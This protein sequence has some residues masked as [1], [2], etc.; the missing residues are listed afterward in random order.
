M[1]LLTFYNVRSEREL[2][3]TVPERIDW[4][5]FLGY[6]L[7]S[8]IPDHSV[9]SKARKRWGVEAFRQF[10]ERIVWQCVEAGQVDGEKIF[11]DSSLI[12]A[13]ASNSSV[14]DRQSLRYQVGRHYKTLEARLTEHDDN[15]G[16]HNE[17][18]RRFVSPTDPDAAI[19]RRGTAKLTYQTHRAVD[20]EAEVITAVTVTPGDV[21]EAHVMT[22]LMDTHAD[23]TG[24]TAK[25]I[26]ADSKYGTIE[27]FLACY[28]RGVAAHIPDLHDKMTRRSLKEGIYPE[29]RFTYDA[30]QDVYIC[31]AGQMLKPATLHKERQKIEYR[32]SKKTCAACS[33]KS[34]CTRSKTGRSIQRHVRHEDL[35]C[36]RESSKTVL[37]RKDIQTRQHLMERSFARGT[38]YGFDQARWRGLWRV[39]IQ[40]YLI[41]AVQN[42]QI[43][44]REG[45]KR[46]LAVAM[47][48]AAVRT[49]ETVD[50]S[51]AEMLHLQ[52]FAHL[53]IVTTRCL[54]HA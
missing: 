13:D 39:N 33:H 49:L 50:R 40:E 36:M 44:I 30:E 19:V 17:V 25:T 52:P 24:R 14:V 18:N 47:R 10:F 38:R 41:C 4:L 32:I 48:A 22:A 45:K 1:L 8:E 16:K 2:M 23:N 21:N 37:A 42:I 9:L 7:D 43:L 51:V 3:D 11:M 46:G 6:D 12:E 15:Y 53:V 5:W 28:D 26:V 54:E 35:Q 29:D 34:A 31:P 20:G 27:N